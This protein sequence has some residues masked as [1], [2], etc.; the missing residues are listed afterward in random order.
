MILEPGPLHFAPASQ[1]PHALRAG[2][3]HLWLIEL[4]PVANEERGSLST[5]EWLRARR[6][7]FSEDRERYIASRVRLRAI[8]GAYLGEESARLAFSRSA[9]GK[10]SALQLEPRG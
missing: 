10:L 4:S 3:A 9:H 8:L 6:F 5:D 2:E 1:P 7:V